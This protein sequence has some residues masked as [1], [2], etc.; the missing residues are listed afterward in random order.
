VDV[1]AIVFFS[2]L[3]AG[4]TGALVTA[5]RRRAARPF[6]RRHE[7]VVYT[8][9]LLPEAGQ[10]LELYT[11]AKEV[12]DGLVFDKDMA[13]SATRCAQ[14][15]LEKSDAA[16]RCSQDEIDRLETENAALRSENELLVNRIETAQQIVRNYTHAKINLF[17]NKTQPTRQR[18]AS[19]V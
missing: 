7:Q 5:N 6:P 14:R 2:I 18:V 4:T 8:K 12:M 10:N 16:L 15:L 11:R 1:F 17:C 19:L 13:T 3:S 9:Y